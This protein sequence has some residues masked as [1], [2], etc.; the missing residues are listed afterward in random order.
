MINKLKAPFIVWSTL[1]LLSVLGTFLVFNEIETIARKAFFEKIELTSQLQRSLGYNGAIHNFKNYILRENLENYKKAYFH[2]G[3]SLKLINQLEEKDVEH[4]FEKEIMQVRKTVEQ[5]I[6]SLKFAKD[7]ITFHGISGSKLDK[8]VAVDDSKTTQ[9]IDAIVDS[10]KTAWIKKRYNATILRR[11][12]ITTIFLMVLFRSYLLYKNDRRIKFSN[13]KLKILNSELE[14]FTYR[15]SHDIRSPVV[16]LKR[17]MGFVKEDFISKN[18]KFIERN[19]E[20][21]EKLTIKLDH[22][23]TSLIQMARFEIDEGGAQVIDVDEII[24]EIFDTQVELAHAEDIQLTKKIS[25]TRKHVM[26]KKDFFMIS[27]N[28]IDNAIKYRHP[29]REPKFVKVRVRD[30]NKNLVLEVIDNG[31]GFESKD[32]KEVFGMFKKLHNGSSIGS[33]LG[34]YMVKKSIDKNNGTIDYDTSKDGTAFIVSLATK[35]KT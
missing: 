19:L 34:M 22:L 13:K 30:D 31:E 1:L 16:S 3:N 5:Y 35:R 11:F 26:S 24:K 4:Q 21:A 6:V 33:G 12:A 17:L 2:F 9:A 28:L 10:L 7:S 14:Q 32:K 23:I 15:I 27:W 18:Y 20:V 25:L 8:L 29:T